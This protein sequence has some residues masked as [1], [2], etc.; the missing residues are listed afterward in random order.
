M[1]GGS[2]RGVSFEGSYPTGASFGTYACM[3]LERTAR[4]V[5]VVRDDLSRRGQQLTRS[6]TGS[7]LLP[8]TLCA[9]A[10]NCCTSLFE[11]GKQKRRKANAWPGEEGHTITYNP[12]VH[13]W[14]SLPRCLRQ[15]ATPPT[16][17][18]HTI[19]GYSRYPIFLR[20]YAAVLR[21]R[22]HEQNGQARLTHI[23]VETTTSTCR[24]PR[25]PLLR[26]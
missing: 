1:G 8:A 21:I 5:V 13:Q 20:D 17:N 26:L 10:C 16:D 14:T 25:D 9:T 4:V 15:L 24:L 3:L 23:C 11:H 22:A 6:R 2:R 7:Q 12:S 19:L 18:T